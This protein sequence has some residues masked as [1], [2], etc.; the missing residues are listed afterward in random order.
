MVALAEIQRETIKHEFDLFGRACRIPLFRTMGQFMCEEVF[1]PPGGPFEGQLFDMDRQPWSR[2]W[3]ELVDSEQFTT[4]VATGGVQQGKTLTCYVG[5]A[6]YYLFERGENVGCGIPQMEM[7]RDKW[8][9]DFKPVI[10]A[11]KYADL[12]PE[13]GQGSKGGEFDAITFK[14]GATL[15][16][17]SAKGNDAKRSGVTFRVLVITEADKFDEASKTS[18]ETSPIGQMIARL[19]AFQT[20]NQRIFIECTVS[21]ASGFIWTNYLAGTASRIAV[22]CPHCHVRSTPEREHLIG[23]QDADNEID[24]RENGRFICPNCTRPWT[25][26]ERR[27][28]NENAV[29]VHRG[30]SVNPDGTVSGTAPKTLTLGFR[31]NAANNM[32]RP[33]SDVSGEE[34]A[35]KNAPED[36]AKAK[37]LCQFTWVKPWNGETTAAGLSEEIIAGRMTGLPRGVI[38]E[39]AE[40]LVVQ[41]DLHLRWHYWTA[42]A[43]ETVQ[44]GAA[45]AYSIVDYGISWNPDKS[46]YG[47]EASILMGLEALVDELES[48]TWATPEGRI[49]EI[50]FGL[51][52]GGYHQEL[53][54]EFVTNHTKQRWRVSK[55][56]GRGDGP[57]TGKYQEAIER[58]TDVRPGDHW[59]YRR[60]PGTAESG[61]NAWWMVF[62]DTTWF[63]HRVQGGLMAIP[64]TEPELPEPNSDGV[65]V[66]TEEQARRRRRPGTVALF[67]DE[68]GVHMR[69]LDAQITRSNFAMQILG[70]IWGEIKNKSK[71]QPVKGQKIGWRKQWDQD[72]WLDTTYGCLVADSVCRAYHPKFR[73][74]PVRPSVEEE[75]SKGFTMPDGRPYLITN[76]EA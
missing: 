65:V 54:V 21:I 22:L 25:E 64:Y 23:Y 69:N 66:L 56:Q 26:E 6:M 72:H 20:L 28:A 52:D 63:M 49:I 4:H 7:A 71:T 29:I 24:A 37:A 50:D 45:P 46:V 44:P 74:K 58:T 17:M 2:L 33:A 3:F 60:Q 61:N 31:W 13:I 9:R 59:C 15:K 36:E 51:I 27:F 68:P 53:A 14:N 30:Q 18:R 8:E 34:F 76:R 47:P 16:F 12:V 43:S 11:S 40:T 57:D 10:K 39:E 5:P 75:N 48:R 73:P 42:L 1:L 35:A 41:I 70:W 38:P 62:A 67:G 55:G 32:L 19:A